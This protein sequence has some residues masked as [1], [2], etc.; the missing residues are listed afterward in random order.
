MKPPPPLF[1]HPPLPIADDTWLIRHL[2]ETASGP[3][4]VS[5]LLVLGAQPTIVDTGARC[6]REQWLADVLGLVDPGDVRWVVVSHDHADH[7]GN[8]EAVL[9]ACPR[10]T[11]VIS[12]A[13]LPRLA[14]RVAVPG[15]RCLLVDDGES[16]DAGDRRLLALR[17]PVYDSA[18]TRGLLDSATGVYWAVDAWGAVTGEAAADAADVD[19]A[20]WRDALTAFAHA[21]APWLADVDPGRWHAAVD[22]VAALRPAVIAPAHGPVVGAERVAEAVAVLR[23]A[24]RRVSPEAHIPG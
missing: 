12:R 1:S 2:H 14:L 5:S 10:A 18:A 20:A 19:S 21:T 22:A 11:L 16:F 24:A 9:D 23:E 7:D 4:P 8:L 17:P 3:L 6:N 15:E 13:L